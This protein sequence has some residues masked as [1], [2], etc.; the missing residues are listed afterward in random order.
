MKYS[1]KSKVKLS[2]DPA[3]SLLGMSKRIEILVLKYICSPIF[4]E[5]LSTMTKI[6][7]QP[8]YSSM[9]ELLKKILYTME[10]YSTLRK[11][12]VLPYATTWIELET[13]RLSIIQDY[14]MI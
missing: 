3:I 8:K 13:I 11:K 6:W 5:A 2:Y 14:F 10:Y 1:K 12:Y 4:T 9:D 7:K